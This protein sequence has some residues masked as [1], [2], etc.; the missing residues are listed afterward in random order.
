MHCHCARRT[1]F[2]LHFHFQY[3][4]VDFVNKKKTES[5]EK[6]SVNRRASCTTKA[7]VIRRCRCRCQPMNE[8]MEQNSVLFASQTKQN[9]K[10]KS[11]KRL[12]LRSVFLS[13]FFCQQTN[14]EEC[15]ILF[16]FSIK[17]NHRSGQAIRRIISNCLS[18]VLSHSPQSRSLCA[19]S[20]ST[21]AYKCLVQRWRASMIRL[22][23]VQWSVTHRRHKYIR[24]H[25]VKFVD[26]FKWCENFVSDI[27]P[28]AKRKI[29]AVCRVDEN[30][31]TLGIG[32][33]R[34]G[35]S[36]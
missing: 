31:F 22:L 11:S 36:S 19:R 9:N 6:R 2:Y 20:F 21:L 35:T 23:N 16:A 27:Q 29:K 25:R 3:V 34:H 15:A 26:I 5:N 18:L 7:I 10:K 30:E 24:T 17:R 13:R 28:A 8:R 4:S 12:S 33:L 14:T 1:R 32:C